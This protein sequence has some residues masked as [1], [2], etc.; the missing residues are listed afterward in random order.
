MIGATRGS[1]SVGSGS[2]T[3]SESHLFARIRPVSFQQRENYALFIY[4]FFPSAYG[5]DDSSEALANNC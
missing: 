5:D 3:L 2:T 1:L 4:L